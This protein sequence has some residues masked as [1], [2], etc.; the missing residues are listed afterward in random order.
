V[1][2]TNWLTF[3][4][5]LGLVS[6]GSNLRGSR[7]QTNHRGLCTLMRGLRGAVCAERYKHGSETEFCYASNS[8]TGPEYRDRSDSF[9]LTP[10]PRQERKRQLVSRTHDNFAQI[11]VEILSPILYM[12]TPGP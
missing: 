8:P 11:E 12:G 6:H 7:Q 4:S 10:L 3:L 9:A 2:E 1:G 5:L